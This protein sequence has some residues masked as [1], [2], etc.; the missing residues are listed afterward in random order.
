MA[1][2]A[3]SFVPPQGFRHAATL[4]LT[5]R[6]RAIAAEPSA[7]AI[8]AAVERLAHELVALARDMRAPAGASHWLIG[9]LDAI[10]DRLPQAFDRERSRSLAAAILAGT[11]T[12]RRHVEPCDVFLVYL[13][14]DRL[15]IAAPLAIELSKRRV[16]VAF[17]AYE[18]TAPAQTAA[19]LAD[20]LAQHR[21]GILLA[22]PAFRRS[23]AGYCV[24]ALP[25]IRV[26]S[27]PQHQGTMPELLEYVD[28]LRSGVL[29]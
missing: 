9:E 27:D 25:R 19:A 23:H 29:K 16:S 24:P 3:A 4:L 1:D 11:G 12:R 7:D 22:T 5:K 2:V 10:V 8:D 13:P 26:L 28:S 17:A 20:G 15:P 21:G 18:V 14:E 6:A